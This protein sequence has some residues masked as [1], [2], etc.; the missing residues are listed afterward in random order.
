PKLVQNRFEIRI[1][2]VQITAATIFFLAQGNGARAAAI[3]EGKQSIRRVE[4]DL[5]TEKYKPY[6]VICNHIIDPYLLSQRL[7]DELLF[8]RIIAESTQM[9]CFLFPNCI[10]YVPLHIITHYVH[11]YYNLSNNCLLLPNV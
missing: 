4:D 6:S 8:A 1:L 9:Y 2:M 5:P 3:V 7:N 11:Y 10:M